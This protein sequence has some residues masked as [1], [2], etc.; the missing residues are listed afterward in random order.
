MVEK[1]GKAEVDEKA[2]QAKQDILST[3]TD[4]G[5]V[6]MSK[7]DDILKQASEKRN[8]AKVR[9][10]M[11]KL[12]PPKEN[13]ITSYMTFD[14]EMSMLVPK[15]S[16]GSLRID[17]MLGGGIPLG[18]YIQLFGPESGGKTLLATFI[19]G[20]FYRK[21]AGVSYFDVEQAADLV[22]TQKQTGLNFMDKDMVYFSRT[23]K[24]SQVYD[25]VDR[26]AKE[27]A[28]LQVIDSFDGMIAPRMEGSNFGDSQ[29]GNK[30]YLHS[31]SLN[32]IVG[33]LSDNNSTLIG[34]S[35]IRAKMDT[36]GGK[37]RGPNESVSGG[38]APKFYATA[39]IRVS[40]KETIMR[41]TKAVGI[42][43]K[44]KVYKNKVG[45]PF[46]EA[47]LDFYFDTGFDLRTEVIEL[48]NELNCWD[49]KAGAHIT[50]GGVK[51]NGIAKMTDWLL[52]P[53]N[54]FLLEDLERRVRVAMVKDMTAGDVPEDGE[55]GD[56]S[57][58]HDDVA[59]KKSEEVRESEIEVEGD[60]T[61][62]SEKEVPQ[63]DAL[64]EPVTEEPLEEP[65]PAPAAKTSRGRSKK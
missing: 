35:Q 52:Q 9:K 54:E 5:L 40:R 34:I 36:S 58:Y 19:A 57:I 47:E 33:T 8:F 44:F 59:Q 3:G 65:A 37:N 17:H 38:H 7:G 26:L 41:G 6:F 14:D 21:G 53:E 50:Y 56:G 30:A 4:T 27:G 49:E 18:R 10:E 1:V 28:M 11:D 39:R 31:D 13:I 48:A 12:Y 22:H 63:P 51:I 45:P 62:V 24:G 43:I 29:M 15:V 32:K 42:R 60:A 64:P 46:R 25:N 2:L 55:N 61:A 23:R 20:S 16:S